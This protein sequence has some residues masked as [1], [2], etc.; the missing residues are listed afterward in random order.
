MHFAI[1]IPTYKR[2]EKLENLLT[3]I[4]ASTHQDFDIHVLADNKDYSTMSHIKRH[5]RTNEKV[6]CY[7]MSKHKFVSGC[8]NHFTKYH[9]DEIKDAM[10]WL[11]D[12]VELDVDCLENLSKDLEACFPDTDGVVGIR[13]RC[14]NQKGLHGTEFGQVALGKKF[15]ERYQDNQVCMISYLHFY[16]D[17]EMYEY[18][19]SLDKFHFSETAKL[20][21]YHPNR[22]PSY[23][24]STHKITRGMVKNLDDECFRKRREKGLLWGESFKTLDINL[25]NKHEFL[26]DDNEYS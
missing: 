11:V 4:L 13:Q 17:R 3:S 25:Q 9:F 23:K 16:Q 18:A 6:K 24:D 12:D 21:H 10:V 26:E 8:W 5:F 20:T 1:V 7:V 14:P 2:V 22:V 19:K 15:I